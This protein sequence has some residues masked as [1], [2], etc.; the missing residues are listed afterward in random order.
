MLMEARILAILLQ[1]CRGHDLGELHALSEPT[2]GAVAPEQ[3][4]L[5]KQPY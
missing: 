2:H 3:Q 4:H 5:E 1:L